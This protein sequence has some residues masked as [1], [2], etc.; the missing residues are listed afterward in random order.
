MANMKE[1][2]YITACSGRSTPSLTSSEFYQVGW[3]GPDDPQNPKNWSKGR[4]W[5]VCVLPVPGP[6][7][8]D[9]RSGADREILSK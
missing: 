8:W 1:I 6:W 7:R 9:L 5:A 4:K 3:D 2:T